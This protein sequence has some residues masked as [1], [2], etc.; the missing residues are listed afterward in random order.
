MYVRIYVV[1]E[2]YWRV[3]RSINN[4]ASFGPTPSKK[5]ARNYLPLF[6]EQ[7]VFTPT[8]NDCIP[9]YKLYCIDI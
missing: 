7:C 1:C 9:S 5:G 6:M 2:K 8:F 3:S 4:T